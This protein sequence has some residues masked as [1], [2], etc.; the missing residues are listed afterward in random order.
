MSRAKVL[1]LAVL[2]VGGLA[3]YLF[4]DQGRE[5]R[6][7]PT[8]EFE[9]LVDNF[10]WT[11]G[12]QSVLSPENDVI[13]ELGTNPQMV[14]TFEQGDYQQIPDVFFF[15]FESQFIDTGEIMVHETGFFRDIQLTGRTV[16]A[17]AEVEV[18][19]EEHPETAMLLQLKD[20]WGTLIGVGYA[21]TGAAKD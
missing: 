20:P 10:E 1:S 8:P 2:L 7:P 5:T 17:K 21:R 16:S 11:I 3:A 15:K 14:V 18:E 19:K 12:G 9:A 4:S 13:L 6:V